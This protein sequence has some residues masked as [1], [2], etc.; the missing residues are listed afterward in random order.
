M[1]IEKRNGGCAVIFENKLYVWGGNTTEK[2]RPFADLQL[3]SDSSD[4]DDEGGGGVAGFDPNKEVET[5]V[6]HSSQTE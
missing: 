5:T 6:T 2:R 1:K 3:S 4:D